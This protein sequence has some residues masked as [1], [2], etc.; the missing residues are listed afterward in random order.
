LVG[1]TFKTKGLFF[2][3]CDEE[4]EVEDEC[5][6]CSDFNASTL[7]R[8]ARRA[9]AEEFMLKVLFADGGNKKIL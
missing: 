2:L 6:C 8:I 3:G 5:L 9:F 4:G 7:C 1:D